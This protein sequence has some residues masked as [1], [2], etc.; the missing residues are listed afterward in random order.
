M[1]KATPLRLA[2]VASERKQKDVAEDAGIS[3]SRLSQ[4]VN[5]HWNADEATRQSIADALGKTVAELWPSD[6]AMA[7]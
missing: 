7:A 4:I 2:I 5:G 3:E 6:E 1:R